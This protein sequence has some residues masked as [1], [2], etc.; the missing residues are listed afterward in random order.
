MTH[1][2]TWDHE[3]ATISEAH[4]GPAL[5][6]G[7]GAMVAGAGGA[8]AQSGPAA[9]PSTVTNPPRPRRAARRP[10]YF[11]DPDVVAVDPQFNA[12]MQPNTAIKRLH[13]GML[14]AEGPAWSARRAV[15]G[16]ERHPEQ[17]TDALVRGRRSRHRVPLSVEQQ[18]QQH[19]RLP[20]P[21]AVLRAPRPP[22]RALRA[23]R[24]RERDRGF[25]SRQAAPTRRTAWWRIPTAAS[26]SPTRR[27][28][29][30]SMRRARCRRR[31]RQCREPGSIRASASRP[32]SSPA[33]ASCHQLL[34]RRPERTRR[35]RVER[36]PGSGSQ[37]ARVLAR[38]RSSTSSVPAGVR[39][40]P[41]RAARTT[42]M[43][44][45][46]APITSCPA[47]GCSATS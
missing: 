46:S 13:T 35:P 8:A 14:W 39:A 17:P 36:G 10:T 33:A 32:A 44:S 42:C 22:G 43:S 21:A 34:P 47:R 18:Q 29:V 45:M 30:S 16:L 41:G 6:A 9:P 38:L 11:W 28:E 1:R 27:M 15:S 31:P 24:H 7:A 23:R 5:A 2:E 40:T 37:R 20:G 3:D 4:A 19:V 25:V 12:I 26:G